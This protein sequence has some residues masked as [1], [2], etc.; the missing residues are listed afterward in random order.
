LIKRSILIRHFFF[1]Q[2]TPRQDGMDIFADNN[3]QTFFPRPS[4]QTVYWDATGLFAATAFLMVL[5]LCVSIGWLCFRVFG[6]FSDD[7]IWEDTCDD[8]ISEM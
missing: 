6:D 8:E 1:L 4:Q 7:A 3:Q 5:F 2:E